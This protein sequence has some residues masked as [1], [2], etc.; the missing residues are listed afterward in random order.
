MGIK[1]QFILREDERGVCQGGVNCNIV[2]RG[3]DGKSLS[4]V[5]P[6]DDYAFPEEIKQQAKEWHVL[7]VPLLGQRVEES[8]APDWCGRT[9]ASMVYNYFQLI[10]GRDP[11]PHYITH[12]KAGDPECLLDLRYPRGERAFWLPADDSLH[13]RG[14]TV[15]PPEGVSYEIQSD[16]RD[17]RL[18]LKGE[19]P[20]PLEEIFPSDLN[21]RPKG[22]G[23][24]LRYSRPTSFNEHEGHL[25][26]DDL[27]STLGEI[28]KSEKNVRER[29]AHLIDCLRA[30]NPVVIY[31]GVGLRNEKK[32]INPRHIIVISG[33]CILTVGG[34]DQLWMVTADPSTK[35]GLVDNKV[36]K[37]P[38]NGAMDLGAR[39]GP[40]DTIFRMRAGYTNKDATGL[41]AFASFN[42]V[43]AKAFFD[44]NP[45]TVDSP[46]DL[47]LDHRDTHGGRYI[48]RKERTEAPAEV[49]DSS[50]SRPKYIFPLRGSSASSNPW[51]SYYNNE[52]LETG[53]G[54]Y[55]VL[56]L[57]RNLHG[58]VHLFPPAEQKTTPVRAIA[59]GYVVAA[60]LP[61]DKASCRDPG[62][63][64]A[65][66][67]WPGFVL[68]RHELE[69]NSQNAEQKSHA[70][71]T[72]YMHLR[73]PKFPEAAHAAP[74]QDSAEEQ[75]EDVVAVEQYFQEVPWFRELYKR[76]FGAWV[77]IS[78]TSGPHKLGALVWSQAP[79]ANAG[80]GGGT[81][82]VLAEDGTAHQI[83]V[84]NQAGEAQ[85]VYKAPPANLGKA[86]DALVGGKV[87]T[88]P[89]PFF[90]VA[91]GEVLGFVGS[92]P[93]DIGMDT[94]R[95]QVKLD[96]RNTAEK[97]KKFELRSGFLHFQVFSPEKD[98]ENGIKLLARLAEQIELPEDIKQAGGRAPKF[99]PV[100]ESAEDN[101]LEVEE[102]EKHLRDNLPEEDR[103]AFTKATHEHFSSSQERGNF[104]YAKAVAALLDSKTSF[105]PEAKKP[106]WKS[107]TPFEYPLTLEIETGYLP[108][109]EK[110]SMIETGSYELELCFEQELAGGGWKKLDCPSGQCGEVCKPGSIKL[111]AGKLSAAK[112]G[113]V[114][115]SLMVPA[116]AERMTLK[117]KQGF[118]IEQSVPLRGAD[119]YLLAQGI[120]RRWRNIRLIQKNE[121]VPDNV[122]AVLNKANEALKP[123]GL[124]MKEQEVVQIAWCDPEKEEHVPRVLANGTDQSARLFDASGWLPPSSRL[125]N[126]HPVSAI[127]LL[128]V[129]DKQNK[130]RVRSEWPVPRFR[131]EDPNPLCSG[132]V[133]SAGER[134]MGE[135]AIAVVIDEDFGYD[136]EH[137]LALR[138]KQGAHV[139]DL[140]QG[141]PA[142]SGG[143]LVHAVQASFW[144]E[145]TLEV[146]DTSTPPKVLTPKKPH[147]RLEAVLSVPR[148]KL[149]GA[150]EGQA[151]VLAE[152]P[153]R[154]SDGNWRW[155]LD[156][157]GPVP[158]ELPGF[159]L[160]RMSKTEDG[161]DA[162]YAN[163]AI[164]VTARSIQAGKGPG[165]AGTHFQLENDFIVGLTEAGKKVWESPKKLYVIDNLVGFKPCFEAMD[166]KV[167]WGLVK[168]LAHL[169]AKKV[170]FELVSFAEDGLSCTLRSATPDKL[171][172]ESTAAETFQRNPGEFALTFD[173]LECEDPKQQAPWVFDEERRVIINRKPAAGDAVLGPLPYSTYR[174]VYR[175]SQP[176]RMHVA[177]ASA[178]GQVASRLDK[179]Q[180]PPLERLDADGLGCIINASGKGVADQVRIAAASGAFN[181]DIADPAQPTRLRLSPNLD[182]KN[183]LF[184][185]FHPGPLFSSLAASDLEPGA[186]RFHWFELAALNGLGLMYPSAGET[187]GEGDGSITLKKFEELKAKTSQHLHVTHAE[188]GRY[189]KVGLRNMVPKPEGSTEEAPPKY[190]AFRPSPRLGQCELEISACVSGVPEDLHQY[191]ACF[192]RRVAGGK[193]WEPIKGSTRLLADKLEVSDQNAVADWLISAHVPFPQP[194]GEKKNPLDCKNEFKL[195]LIAISPDFVPQSLEQV[196][197]YDFTPRWV[198]GLKVQPKGELLELRCHAEGIEVPVKGSKEKAAWNVARE[199]ELVIETDPVQQNPADSAAKLAEHVKFATPTLDGKRGGCDLNGDFVATIDLAALALNV[200]YRFTVRRA[201]EKNKKPRPVRL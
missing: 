54:G 93:A 171:L 49:V 197:E 79:V 68:I 190:L 27:R 43:R 178:L 10:K 148:P 180:L 67:N 185:S 193:K 16:Y 156:F 106:D 113:V 91:T 55:Y 48:Y 182:T 32:Q 13:K 164:P 181:V 149:V 3:E 157:E 186:Q 23:G 139:L 58:G 50:F 142:A 105:A 97:R 31:T 194:N 138:L 44:K 161:A 100:E 158:H 199:F 47:I 176:L 192:S 90:P 187:T 53:I 162:E 127:W 110:N 74:A 108:P 66:G 46:H 33:Y 37:A 111:D 25:L 143:N 126:L 134:R 122:K 198:G 24:I 21:A 4:R 151:A 92:L 130:A 191:Y 166:I 147:K 137:Q 160:L 200:S 95:F 141:T 82:K 29:F 78:D 189:R 102:I 172:R 45:T 123:S 132:W 20:I 18:A 152:K 165:V 42:L 140:T 5:F 15:S 14:W 94:R 72:L 38:T 62:V 170:H 75:A 115:L 124:R 168:G 154:Q 73:S 99:V 107:C 30:N 89:E 195:E 57:Q 39:I 96:H 51:Q 52:S 179:K 80:E 61:G 65:L 83:S 109:P 119:G 11:R 116:L 87:V 84:C 2:E 201:L 117:A 159:I 103:A 104:G 26:P 131:K 88:F 63:L 77:N 174:K 184:I 59:P 112:N 133:K 60:R 163:A 129:L 118:F 114:Q 169:A 135:T 64:E 34:E 7:K 41:H 120:T 81:Y 101:F 36:F 69:E 22:V 175:S 1:Q 71:Y 70:F 196:G 12:S 146:T 136:L 125:E 28:R 144:G 145:W 128:N 85:W 17:F 76:R 56:G 35:R 6:V 9:S 86:Q 188:P 150:T 98:A 121:W 167:G 155:R 183:S 40:T 8:Q 19:I 173:P 177:L 153:R